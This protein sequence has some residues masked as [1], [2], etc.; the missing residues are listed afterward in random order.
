M[1]LCIYSSE[2]VSKIKVY[3]CKHR[4][5]KFSIEHPLSKKQESSVVHVTG[6]EVYVLRKSYFVSENKITIA[7]KIWH[8]THKMNMG[9]HECVVKQML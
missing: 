7:L 6:K 2:Q 9:I 4:K 5:Y 8:Q 3:N 1:K